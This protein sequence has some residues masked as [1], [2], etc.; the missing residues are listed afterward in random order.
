MCLRNALLVAIVLSTASFA[1]NPIT[2]DSPFQV[3]YA[4]SLNSGDAFIHISNS[5]ANGASLLGPGVGAA[6][7]ICA[8]VYAFAPDEQL[9]SCCSCLVTPNGLVSLAVKRDL[10]SNTLTGVGLDSA[11]IKLVSTLAGTGGSG[12]SCTNSAALVGQL[13]R[14]P[15]LLAW[16]TTIQPLPTGGFTTVETP[17]TPSTLS[18]GELASIGG[19]CASILGNGSGAG[20]CGPCTNGG[21]TGNGGCTLGAA[22]PNLSGLR[23]GIPIATPIPIGITGGTSPFTC[24]LSGGSLPTGT[25]LSGCSIVGTPLVAGTFTYSFTVSDSSTPG[26]SVTITCSVTI[27]GQ[28]GPNPIPVCP[29]FC[30]NQGST[31]SACAEPVS[32]TQGT[33]PYT[34][35]AVGLPT[36]LTI[37][38]TTPASSACIV[39]TVTAPPGSFPYTVK[40]VDSV[41]AAGL[42]GIC[43]VTVTALSVPCP[44]FSTRNG[45]G[46]PVQGLPID[47][48]TITPTGGT[49]PYTCTVTG[50]PWIVQSGPGGC[51]L[52]GTPLVT[53][54]GSPTQCGALPITITVTDSSCG[55]TTINCTVNVICVDP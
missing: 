34:F 46:S 9:V 12:T 17:F 23:V 11:V 10:V 2:A 41:G 14:V 45:R 30:V 5:G 50:Q 18:A 31:I 22:C 43:T 4:T 36:S 42:S 54:P 29:S 37:Q 27:P 35:S 6:G 51:T 52:S 8:N 21:N 40:A 1:Q 55:R 3:R 44:A 53:L 24:T 16:G 15:G 39:G 47:V 32:A 7:N 13:S 20:I 49:G 33:A 38:P 28:Q 48:V 26:C 19:R 25:S